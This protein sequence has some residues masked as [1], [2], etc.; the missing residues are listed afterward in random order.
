MNKLGYIITSNYHFDK[1]YPKTVDFQF[2]STSLLNIIYVFK[3]N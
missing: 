1:N 3:K 2:Y